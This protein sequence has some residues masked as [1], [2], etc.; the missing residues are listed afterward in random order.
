MS[1]RPFYLRRRPYYFVIAGALI[2]GTAGILLGRFMKLDLPDVTQL[3]DYQPPVMSRVLDRNGELVATFAEEKRQ[4]LEHGEVP[5]VFRDALIASEDSNF[6]KH[7]G[8]DVQGVA[9]A[10]WRDLLAGRKEQGAS[11]LTMQLAGNLFLD[12]SKKTVRRKAQ[13]ALLAL[14]IERRY[15][16]EEILRLYSNQVHFGHGLYGL[17]AASRFYFGVPAAE[18]NQSQAATLVGLLP[19]PASY[20]PLRNPERALQRRNLVLRRMVDEEY[21]TADAADA[22]REAPIIVAEE[23][24]PTDLAPYFTEEVRRWL[25]ETYGS[26]ALYKEGLEVRTT[27]QPEMQDWANVAVEA[28]L[29][30]LDKRQGWRPDDVRRIEEGSSADDFS[31]PDWEE[32]LA[33]DRIVEG[34]VTFVDATRAAVRVGPETSA[35]LDAKAIE[36]T[37]K[38][39]PS[40]LLS[41]GDIVQVRVTAIDEETG[42]PSLA[43]DQ[44][45]AVQGALVALDPSTGEVLAMVGGLDFGRSEFNRATQAKRQTGSSFKTFVFA[46]AFA[47][48]ATLADTVVDEPTVFLDRSRPDPYQPENFHRDYYQTIT[49]RRAL[50]KSANIASVKLLDRIGYDAVLD[51]SDRL[52]IT[53]ELLPFPSLALGSFEV[54]LLELTAAYGAFANQGVWVQPHFIAD[55]SDRAGFPVYRTEPLVRDAVSPQAAY[56]TTQALEGVI[57]HG[58]GKSALSL[59]HPIAGKTGTTDDYSDAWFLGYSPTLA[60]GVWVGFDEPRPLGRSETGAKAALPIWKAFMAKVLEDREPLE[61]PVPEGI[62]FTAID[63]AS[64]LKASNPTACGEPFVEAFVEGTEPTAFCSRQRTRQLA[65][66]Y[67]LQGYPLSAKGGLMIPGDELVALLESDPDLLL[68]FDRRYVEVLGEEMPQRFPLEVQPPSGRGPRQADDLRRFDVD[69]WRGTDGRP[70]RIVWMN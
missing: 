60:V 23:Q 69:S 62:D 31:S 32:P 16:K 20:S 36:W 42:K 54:T 2:A 12:R 47:E 26:T 43:L 35:D 33:V 46:A 10:L 15:S 21:L 58:T 63:A 17:E 52:G 45:P 22:I 70:A 64:G 8:V 34:V 3:E 56:L 48:G 5:V 11:T 4:L 53:S 13:E 40:D 49:L 41:V 19:R 65:L 50:E 61:F 30:D 37:E 59:G 28:G 51:L 1:Q 18:L 25:Q 14:D 67:T 27:V 29:R 9:R 55:V 66:P 44:R 38:K 24:G 7:T 39:K 68:S 57:Q 6:W